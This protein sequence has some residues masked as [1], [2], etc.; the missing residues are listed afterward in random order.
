MTKQLLLVLGLVITISS[1]Y[2]Q[3]RPEKIHQLQDIPWPYTKCG[4]GDWSIE[5]LTFSSSPK[6]NIKVTIIAVSILFI[7][8]RDS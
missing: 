7:L 3:N 5:K 6:R 1:F 2:I 4:D 8:V